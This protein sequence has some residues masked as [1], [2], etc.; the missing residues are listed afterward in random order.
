[1][2]RNE[3]FQCQMRLHS[4]HGL[5]TKTTN[6]SSKN[7]MNHEEVAHVNPSVLKAGSC[8]S[9]RS[10]FTRGTRAT[11]SYGEMMM[12][13]DIS[14]VSSGRPSFDRGY[15][16]RLSNMSDGLDR[17]FESPRKSV[18]GYSSSN[19]LSS[20]SYESSSSPAMVSPKRT[21]EA[22]TDWI[23]ICSQSALN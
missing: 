20:L 2:T 18:G 12:D 15:P 3:I 10:P 13:S 23:L 6:R 11:K 4:L 19:G 8:A 7:S 22:L 16:P 17:S 9:N 21:K 1:M 14:F 5:C